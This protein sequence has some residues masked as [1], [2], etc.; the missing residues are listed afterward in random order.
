MAAAEAL[1]APS[2]VAEA[3]W[4][5]ASALP[6]LHCIRSASELLGSGASAYHKSESIWQP[7]DADFMTCQN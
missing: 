2:A 3:A 7:H 5:P 1:S 6:S 4:L